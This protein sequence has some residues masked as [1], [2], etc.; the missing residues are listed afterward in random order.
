MIVLLVALRQEL[1]MRCMKYKLTVRNTANTD[2][3]GSIQIYL[4]S[5]E[6]L[7]M[8]DFILSSWS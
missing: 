6:Q 3:I 8:N 7:E 5:G 4:L 2:E 1:E